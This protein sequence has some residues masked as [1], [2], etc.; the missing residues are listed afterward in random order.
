M[1]LAA[2]RFVDCIHDRR[3]FRGSDSG[4]REVCGALGAMFAAYLV[5]DFNSTA[6]VPCFISLYTLTSNTFWMARC[7]ALCFASHGL[8]AGINEDVL[9]HVD[10]CKQLR[11]HVGLISHFLARRP[12]PGSHAEIGPYTIERITL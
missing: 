10:L 11:D 4:G 5:A 8:I 9:A 3:T 12:L 6:V 2:G 1:V 7:F